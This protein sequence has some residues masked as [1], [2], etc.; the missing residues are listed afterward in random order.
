MEEAA[1]VDDA[2]CTALKNKSPLY[3]LRIKFPSS[4]HEGGWKWQQE[5]VQ[6][7]SILRSLIAESSKDP[8]YLG[9]VT[10]LL[11][12]CCCPG[13]IIE[14]RGSTGLSG[15]WEQWNQSWRIPENEGL[16]AFSCFLLA[17]SLGTVQ[18][19]SLLTLPAEA[20]AFCFPASEQ[21]Q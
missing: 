5:I 13:Q 6:Q 2:L 19:C 16:Q 1:S 10:I 12:K 11:V 4:S 14:Y 21:N 9:K 3:F 20:A 7:E 17:R 18:K 15:C 8:C